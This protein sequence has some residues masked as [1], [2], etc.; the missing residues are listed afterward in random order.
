MRQENRLRK[1]ECSVKRKEQETP[2][3]YDWRKFAA[4]PVEELQRLHAEHV[5]N[6][7]LTPEEEAER[8]QWR[9]LPVEELLRM[10]SEN[11]R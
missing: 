6:K 5:E 10:H 7:P 3:G 11:C 2:G 8:E 9:H 1:L 4:L